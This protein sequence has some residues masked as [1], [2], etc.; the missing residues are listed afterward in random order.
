MDGATAVHQMLPAGGTPME[1]E[2]NKATFENGTGSNLFDNVGGVLS[3]TEM[4]IIEAVRVDSMI[5]TSSGGKS[6]LATVETT[7]SDITVRLSICH[8]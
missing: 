8:L 1:V 2:V 7:L 5:R 6:T 3:F 4:S